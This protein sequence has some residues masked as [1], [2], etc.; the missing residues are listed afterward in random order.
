MTR[1]AYCSI[2][3]VK[4]ISRV[5][6]NKLGLAEDAETQLDNILEKW[7]LEASALIDN[8]TQS[9]L[10]DDDVNNTT[11]KYYVY[12]SVSSRIVANM[13]ALS[14]VYK[15]HNVVKVNDWSTTLIDNNIFTNGLKGELANYKEE[16]T[17]SSGGFNAL[18]VKGKGLFDEDRNQI[19]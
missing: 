15:S 12:K 1:I 4:D 3:D 19:G 5:K 14:S 18:T 10:T 7:I 16:T 6:P 11:T 8:Y 2:E 17:M 9:P 13:C